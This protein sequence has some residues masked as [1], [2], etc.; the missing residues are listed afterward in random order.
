MVTKTSLLCLTSRNCPIAGFTAAFDTRIS[1]LPKLLMAFEDTIRDK[2]RERETH[3]IEKS[4]SVLCFGHVTDH[5]FHVEAL[6]AQSLHRRVHILLFART[7][8]N[9]RA[10]FGQSSGNRQTDAEREALRA[11]DKTRTDPSVEAVMA[12]TLL[13]AREEKGRAMES[14]M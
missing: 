1:N 6:F 7:D 11:E 8:D 13:R 10:V 9:S 2:I 4:L 12:A 5:S 3:A 14:M